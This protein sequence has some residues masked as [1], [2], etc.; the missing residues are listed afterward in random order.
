[1]KVLVVR[2]GTITAILLFS[3]SSVGQNAN[4]PIQIALQRW[5]QMNTA[6]LVQTQSSCVAPEGMVFDGT[7]VWVACSGSSELE[8]YNAADTAFIRKVSLTNSPSY[9]LYDG[10]NVWATNP[11]SNRLTEV[12]ASTGTV[13]GTVT[14]GTTPSGLAFDGQYIWVTNSGSNTLSQVLATTR[15]VTNT[16]N[17]S[18]SGYNNCIGP[19]NI[20]FISSTISGVNPSIWVV[21]SR[22]P[23][24]VIELTPT[25][26][27]VTATATNAV[28]GTPNSNNIAFDGRYIWLPTS[29][30]PAGALQGVLQIDTTTAP[31]SV[32]PIAISGSPSPV[33][34]A[35][36]GKYVWVARGDG[37]VSKILISTLAIQATRLTGAGPAYFV[38]FDGGFAWVSTPNPNGG[39][40]TVSKM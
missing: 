15:T 3:G 36:D 14:V 20:A 5:Y 13:L 23:V 6:T 7:H 2:I 33:A 21:C 29:S 35:F 32:N 19:T 18:G 22:V 11:S 17:V 28:G 24:Q 12:Q 9:L 16:I 30:G 27:Y 34:V 26:A 40:Y 39:V 4:N 31:P 1:M 37:N 8:E 10:A 25:G 38:V